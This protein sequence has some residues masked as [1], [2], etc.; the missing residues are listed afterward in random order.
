MK[1][2]FLSLG[3]LLLL[4]GI[5]ATTLAQ[6]SKI[7][8][9]ENILKSKI[10]DT[11]RVDIL[12]KI[13]EIYLYSNQEKTLEYV[14]KAEKIAINNNDRRRLSQVFLLKA[15]VSIDKSKFDE[16]IELLDKAENYAR[17]TKYLKV[18]ASV[19]GAKGYIFL[20]RKEYDKV[21]IFNKDAI[22][23]LERIKSYDRLHVAYNNLGIGYENTDSLDLALEYYQKAVQIADSISKNKSNSLGYSVNIALLKK[24]KGFFEEALD[25]YY[26]ILDNCEKLGNIECIGIIQNNISS[27]Y[28]E[29][30]QIESAID[31]LNKSLETFE[32][33]KYPSSIMQVHRD[34]GQLY[35]ENLNY[36]K[37]IFHFEKYV[38]LK[39]S[40][41]NEDNS[42]ILEEMRTKYETEKKEQ[43][44][45]LLKSTNAL[46][47]SELNRQ[48]ILNIGIGTGAGLVLLVLFLVFRNLQRERKTK[49]IINYQNQELEKR[50]Q[51]INRQNETLET[52]Y[53][54]LN[55]RTKNLLT[56][57]EGSLMYSHPTKTAEELEQ[58]NRLRMST[59]IAY[60]ELLNLR[61]LESKDRQ[62]NPQ[63]LFPQITQSAKEI[64]QVPNWEVTTDIQ[65]KS[66]NTAQAQG[67]ALIISEAVINAVKYA[68]EGIDNP[69]F[70]VSLQ[71]KESQQLELTIAD[72]G[73]GLSENQESTDSQGI[74]LIHEFTEKMNAE[75]KI[76]TV[77]GTT[78]RITTAYIPSLTSGR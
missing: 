4:N 60:N 19:Y 10:T 2:F 15:N 14:D 43:E 40:L 7:D 30:G 65:V 52:Y 55:H 67:M 23:I 28:A 42:K 74:Q 32:K 71:E 38:E 1:H 22:K 27:V 6:Q 53:R 13:A 59:V 16:A 47:E 45:A 70:E 50:N 61:E 69:K 51:K 21:K 73:I 31:Y 68:Y 49:E 44:N 75:L 72:N 39:D 5:T 24:K 48:Y 76:S 17:Q 3:I 63:D 29:I 8:S 64:F 11:I 26:K 9:L 36:E 66:L 54:D 12:L 20:K 58:E 62:I 25:E 34:L 35:K 77:N 18:Q 56:G 37:A 33:L 78:Y 57:L 41:E 46:Q